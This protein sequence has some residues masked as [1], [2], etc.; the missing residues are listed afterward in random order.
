M[1]EEQKPIP[2]FKLFD[3]TADIGVQANGSELSDIFEQTAR[4]MYTII[5]HNEVPPIEPI[6]E[7]D[8]ELTSSDLEQLFVD[9]LN[10]ILFIFST[11]QIA[12]CEYNIDID[13]DNFQLKA[14]I[15]G[16]TLTEDEL[17][18]TTEIKAVTFHML[19]IKKINSIWNSKVIFDI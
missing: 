12:I 17:T 7:F 14:R 6:G 18:E 13:S 15:K 1:T 19:E 3:H 16:K 11:E 9:W 10:E 2:G 8:I 4:S 5:F